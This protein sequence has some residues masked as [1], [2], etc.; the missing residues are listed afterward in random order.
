MTLFGARA[1]VKTGAEGVFCGAL[2][3]QG[4]G[5]ALKCEDGATRAAEVAMAATIARFLPMSGDERT[6][7]DRFVR[8]GLRNWNGISVGGLRPAEALT[9]VP[10]EAEG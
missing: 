6:K 8:K 5:I 7:L 1:M 2:P 3:E 4:L 10:G 9:V